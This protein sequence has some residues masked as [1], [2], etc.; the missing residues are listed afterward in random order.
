MIK[1]EMEITGTNHCVSF[2]GSLSSVSS[3]ALALAEALC[4]IDE[5]NKHTDQIQK[6]IKQTEKPIDNLEDFSLEGIIEL[7]GKS[8]PVSIILVHMYVEIINY[9][10]ILF[11]VILLLNVSSWLTVLK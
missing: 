4:S 8:Y 10:Q 7:M 6:F 1:F 11:R 5:E 3:V 2:D 9:N